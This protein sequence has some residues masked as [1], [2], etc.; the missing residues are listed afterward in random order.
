MLQA[1]KQDFKADQK[2]NAEIAFTQPEE[3]HCSML[4]LLKIGEPYDIGEW[5]VSKQRGVFR[6]SDR[7]IEVA[8]TQPIVISRLL[9][10]AEDGKYRVEIKFLLKGKETTI[11]VPREIISSRSKIVALSSL[12]VNVTDNTAKA[13]VQYFADIQA[14]NERVIREVSSSSRLGWIDC[15]GVDGVRKK[16]FIPYKDEVVFDSEYSIKSLFESIKTQGDRE[17]WYSHIKKLRKDRRPEFLIN[18]AATFSSVL[19]EPC[20][21]LPFIVSLW[22]PTEIGKSVILQTCASVWA[23]PGEGKYITDAKAT[24]TA[25]EIRLN[26]LNSLP[27]LLDDMA[28]ITRRSEEEL[29]TIIYRWCAGVGR[30]RSNKELGLNKL[31]SWRNCI[32]TNGERSMVDESMQG[33]AINRVIDIEYSDPDGKPIFDGRTGNATAQLV[34]KNFGFAGRDFVEILLNKYGFESINY[35]Y[36]ECYEELKAAAEEMGVEK[37]EKQ[38]VPMALILTA[39]RLTEKEL[40]KDGVLIDVKQCLEYLRNK[41]DV[42][43]NERAYIYLMDTIAANSFKF[44][45]KGVSSISSSEIW[46]CWTAENQVAI[47]GSIFNRLLKDGGFQAKAFLSWCKKKNLI[48][49]DSKGNPKKNIRPGGSPN[50]CRAVFILTDYLNNEEA[51]TLKNQELEEDFKQLPF[52]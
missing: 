30:D 11:Y 45:E 17:K 32:I 23:D 48:E 26:V 33:G 13:L 34:K 15:V 19:V 24:S 35:M 52:K 27:M 37:Q 49:C 7:G 31:T 47:I 50:P 25:V 44:T 51:E 21:V 28:Q 18:L 6:Y 10:N 39:D 42:S 8:C 3:P 22:G 2:A 41:G 43:E 40:F 16:T 20:N 1:V 14:R 12:G 38:I 46:G 36:N 4:D 9:K 29:N 5:Y